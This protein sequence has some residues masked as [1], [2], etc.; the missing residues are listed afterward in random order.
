MEL[1]FSVWP[2]R[3]LIDTQPMNLALVR[4]PSILALLL[5]LC[6]TGPSM[7]AARHSVGSATLEEEIDSDRNWAVALDQEARLNVPLIVQ[8]WNLPFPCGLGALLLIPSP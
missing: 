7:Q 4:L 6:L 3:A 1:A 2:R 8:L 5:V